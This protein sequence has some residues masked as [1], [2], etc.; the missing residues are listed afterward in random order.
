[1]K[2]NDSDDDYDELPPFRWDC[3]YDAEKRYN[4]GGQDRYN[5]LYICY[6]ILSVK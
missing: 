3:F 2:N 5:M 6:M 4:Y 1:M